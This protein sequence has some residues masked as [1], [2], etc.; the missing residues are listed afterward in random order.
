MRTR[1][2]AVGLLAILALGNSGAAVTYDFSGVV[3]WGLAGTPYAARFSLT[4][5]TPITHSDHYH[6]QTCSFD[7]P[8]YACALWPFGTGGYHTDMTPEWAGGD[9]VEFLFQPVPNPNPLSGIGAGFLFPDGAF[10]ADGTYR[11]L[12]ELDGRLQVSGIDA[13]VPEPPALALV[14]LALL[15]LGFASRRLH[16]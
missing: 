8:G 2:A 4:V 12:G 13:A 16:G 11:T 5:A 3:P 10:L 1:C 7:A 15:G 14:S 6:P 9:L